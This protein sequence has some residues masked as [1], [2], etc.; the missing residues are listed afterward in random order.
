MHANGASRENVMPQTPKGRE[1]YLLNDLLNRSDWITLDALSDVL[2]VSHKTISGDIKYV[3]EV[4]GRFDLSLARRPHYGI[5]VVGREVDRRLCLASLVINGENGISQTG[6]RPDDA[7]VAEVSHCIE[8]V[9]QGED[10][11]LDT[12]ARQSLVVHVVIAIKRIRQDCYIPMSPETSAIEED[13][14]FGFSHFTRTDASDYFLRSSLPRESYR[15]ASI[16]PR[17]AG[18]IIHR[19]DVMQRIRR[20]LEEH[21]SEVRAYL[22]QNPS[23]IFFKTSQTPPVGAMA[24]ITVLMTGTTRPSERVRRISSFRRLRWAKRQAGNGRPPP[25]VQLMTSQDRPTSSSRVRPHSSAATGL[26]STMRPVLGSTM[27]MPARTPF[28]MRRSTSCSSR[29]SRSTR[30]LSVTSVATP[31]M[32]WGRPSASSKRARLKIRSRSRP[33][34]SSSMGKSYPASGSFSRSAV[35]LQAGAVSGFSSVFTSAAVVITLF[36]FTPLLYNLPQSVLAAVIMNDGGHLQVRLS[37]PAPDWLAVD[38]ADDGCGIPAGDLK[39]I[40]EPFFSTKQKKGGTGLGLSITYGL[41]QELGGRLEVAS[42]PGQGAT[43]TVRLPLKKGAA[44]AHPAGG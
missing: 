43:F 36:F 44:D 15:S 24:V 6:A 4:L 3:E 5:R 7:I 26:I 28:R 23:Y 21:P 20:Y 37:R 16:P 2:Y 10:V 39:H 35:N 19:G 42:E 30:L 33:L 22:T 32:P 9:L 41:V 13:D 25:S 31:T 11:V 1:L 14:L 38:V 27:K 18:G 8:E 29:R 34:A 17:E 12:I 40:F